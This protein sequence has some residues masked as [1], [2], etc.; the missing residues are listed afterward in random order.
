MTRQ[1]PAGSLD[2]VDVG[3]GR[4]EVTAILDPAASDAS[5]PS[6]DFRH[7][8][9]QGGS[10]PDDDGSVIPLKIDAVTQRLRASRLGT[11]LRPAWSFVAVSIT[12]VS[13][14]RA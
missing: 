14:H 6:A 5:G 7:F 3:L 13:E 9:A 1:A 11:A 10:G 8:R 4:A 12:E 2:P